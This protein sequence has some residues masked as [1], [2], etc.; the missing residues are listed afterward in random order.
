MIDAMAANA[1]F[2]MRLPDGRRKDGPDQVQLAL[3]AGFAVLLGVLVSGGVSGEFDFRSVLA[4]PT[5]FSVP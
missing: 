1:T 2:S 3:G 4:Y 5:K